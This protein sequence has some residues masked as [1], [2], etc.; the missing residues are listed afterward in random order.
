MQ[1]IRLELKVL[2]DRY[3]VCRF[4]PDKR[5]VLDNPADAEFYSITHTAEETS[6]FMPERLAK[7]GWQ[8]E[9]GWR[10]L[11]VIGPLDFSMIGVLAVL[12]RVLAEAGISIF[13]ISTYD[14]DYLFVKEDSLSQAVLILEKEGMSVIQS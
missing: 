5:P 10:G 2:K 3:A 1:T 9:K 8:C 13:A 4:Q 12:S 6:I 11:Q 7:V 14:T